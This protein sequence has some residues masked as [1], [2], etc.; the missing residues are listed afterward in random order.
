MRDE[1]IFFD[2]SG[3]TRLFEE[4]DGDRAALVAGLRT[5][6]TLR[7]SALNV[8]ETARTPSEEVRFAKLH[9]Y[10]EVGG[11]ASPVTLWHS[12]PH[13]RAATAMEAAA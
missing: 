4:R 2:N 6:G 3:L 8:Y 5:L 7:V 11:N 12:S 9:F 13:A 10:R 1:I